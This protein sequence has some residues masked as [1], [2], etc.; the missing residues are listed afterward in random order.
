MQPLFPREKG[1]AASASQKT[2][3]IRSRL[4]DALKKDAERIL[5]EFARGIDWCERKSGK[6]FEEFHGAH[7]SNGLARQ[8]QADAGKAENSREYAFDPAARA[9][10]E[11]HHGHSGKYDGIAAENGHAE[12]DAAA[13][14]CCQMWP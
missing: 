9:T 1:I 12:R 14:K 8:K 4:A 2:D 11:A 10:I 5:H 6:T 3:R 13:Q 7:F